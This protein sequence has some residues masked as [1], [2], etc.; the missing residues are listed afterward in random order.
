MPGPIGRI[1]VR[2][3]VMTRR[4]HIWAA[5]TVDE[6]IELL[7]RVPAGGR[8]PDGSYPRNSVNGLVE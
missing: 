4:F 7:T 6:G 1:K 8:P 5:S 2:N 3:A